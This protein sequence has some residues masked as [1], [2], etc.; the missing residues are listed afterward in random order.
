M[1]LIL[2]ENRQRPS[3]LSLGLNL[4]GIVGVTYWAIGAGIRAE[5]STPV[6]T[7]WI[8]GV[9]IGTWLLRTILVLS[10]SP[11]PTRGWTRWLL[12]GTQWAMVVAGSF[13]ASTL[14]SLT[15]VPALVA[16]VVVTADLTRPLGLGLAHAAVS[17]VAIAFGAVP[18]GVFT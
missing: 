7:W 17:A 13:A 10:I 2:D 3:G 6:W 12:D 4:V 16:V 18:F 11:P 1:A 9:A 5:P 14:D 15:I 8:G